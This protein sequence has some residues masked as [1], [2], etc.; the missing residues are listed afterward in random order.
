[1]L[2]ALVLSAHAAVCTAAAL[3]L[4]RTALLRASASDISLLR[5]RSRA[6]HAR[7]R[8]LLAQL[9]ALRRAVVGYADC[10]ALTAL[11]A[12]P[13]RELQPGSFFDAA[14]VPAALQP[15]GADDVLAKALLRLRDARD[16]A[17]RGAAHAVA[18][19]GSA[20]AN[21]RCAAAR[22][23]AL[24]ASLRAGS[25][26]S[27]A[28]ALGPSGL[29]DSASLF[30][31]HAADMVSDDAPEG[32]GLAGELLRAGVAARVDAEARLAAGLVRP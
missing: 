18:D 19:A 13:S 5:R 17:A 27:L 1:M 31:L 11:C 30:S 2:S 20:L 3:R 32:A 15:A 25:A 8:V 24:L 16:A 22:L 29:L 14:L 23:G 28:R 4:P 9:D 12:L 7:V 6:A 21:A 26:G 10:A